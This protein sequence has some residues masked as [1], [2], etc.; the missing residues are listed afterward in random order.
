MSLCLSKFFFRKENKGLPLK[1]KKKFF[2]IPERG[3][4][5]EFEFNLQSEKKR[6]FDFCIF[7]SQGNCIFELLQDHNKICF[8]YTL[9]F[10]LDRLQGFLFTKD[11]PLHRAERLGKIARHYMKY[12]VLY[13]AY[14]EPTSL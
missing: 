1:S 13:S 8:D 14:T 2:P 6:V 3:L 7:E 5:N 12:E 4:E 11:L 10:Y 9:D